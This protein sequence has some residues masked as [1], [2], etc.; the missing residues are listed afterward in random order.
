V[1]HETPIVQMFKGSNLERIFDNFAEECIRREL[2]ID[3]NGAEGHEIYIAFQD[4]EFMGSFDMEAQE[5]YLLA[6]KMLGISEGTTL[7]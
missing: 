2:S 1:L 7:H 5:G 6:G 4:Q 3:F